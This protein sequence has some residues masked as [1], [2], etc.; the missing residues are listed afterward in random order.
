[1][2]TNSTDF[3]LRALKLLLKLIYLIFFNFVEKDDKFVTVDLR[4]VE[5]LLKS[6]FEI[7]FNLVEGDADL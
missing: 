6:V 2:T 5:L 7:F 3:D 1:M 4:A